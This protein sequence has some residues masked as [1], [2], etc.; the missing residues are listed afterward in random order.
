MSWLSKFKGKPRNDPQPPVLPGQP[1]G[2]DLLGLQAIML[3]PLP[4]LEKAEVDLDFLRARLADL[5]RDLSMDPVEPDEALRQLQALDN[6]S[7]RRL[8]LV[9]R[10]FDDDAPK[11]A[12]AIKSA[13]ELND[14]LLGFAREHQLLTTEILLESNLR[15]EEF[16]RH[17]IARLGA[18][19]QDEEP[20]DSRDRLERL[21]YRQLLA[22]AER[23]KVSAAE[24]TEYI[25]KLQEEQEK[26]VGRRGKF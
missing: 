14:L 10:A 4:R 26:R 23:A 18:P 15:R 6:E 3:A 5:C 25:R 1:A 9:V 20:A 17:F 24:R 21:D 12:L 22:A 11:R 13:Q 16:V 8:A 19:I 2:L 7:R